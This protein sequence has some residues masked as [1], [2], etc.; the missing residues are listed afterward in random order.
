M[1]ELIAICVQEE[2]R[3]K[4]EKVDPTINMITKINPPK[5]YLNESAKR[6]PVKNAHS[7]KNTNDFKANKTSN[8]KCFFC[9]RPRHMKK[10]CHKY[11]RWLEKQEAKGNLQ[12]FVCFESNLVDVLSNSWLLDTGCPVHV[13]NTLQGF[14]RKRT[15]NRNEVNVFVGDGTKVEVKA[16][17]VVNLQLGRS[18]H[19]L[20]LDDIVY[21]LSMRRN[22]I[23]ISKLVLSKYSFQF[24]K[25]GFSL[26]HNSILVAKG[27][28]ECGLFHLNSFHLL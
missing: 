13:T 25:D 27:P 2:D 17:G 4:S 22:L 28:V 26:F 3:I 18:S 24:N 10:A 1:N 5:S 21:V 8:Y 23:S 9:K 7:P 12:S 15:P 11:K 20:E 6:K 16:V 19:C 14:L